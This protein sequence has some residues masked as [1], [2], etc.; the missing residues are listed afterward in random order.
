MVTLILLVVLGG[1]GGLMAVWLIDARGLSGLLGPSEGRSLGRSRH[2]HTSGATGDAPPETP[3]EHRFEPLVPSPAG[4]SASAAATTA[5]FEPIEV[6][7][8]PRPGPTA[9]RDRKRVPAAYT[10]VEGTYREVARVPV[11]RKAVSLGLLLGILLVIGVAIAALTAATFGA[12]AE[13]VDGAVG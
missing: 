13:L 9:R 1:G 10:A 2:G 7:L 12:L 4:P 5:T 11:W 3:R 6:P 8:A